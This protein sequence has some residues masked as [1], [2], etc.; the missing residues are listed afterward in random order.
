VDT[1]KNRSIE[2]TGLGLAIARNLCRLMGGDITVQSVYGEGSTF[3]AVIPQRVIDP[4][5]FG[6]GEIPAVSRVGKKLPDIK[7]IAPDAHILAVDDIDTNLTVLKGLLAPYQI[8]ITLCASGAEAIDLVKKQTFDFVLMDHMMPEMDGIET[9]AAI[10]EWQKSQR[11]ATT[12]FPQET[13]IIALTANAV[14]GMREMFFEKGFNDYLSKPIEIAKLDEL[15][16]KWVPKEK[17]IKTAAP[18]RDFFETGA[19]ISIPGIE[20][21]KGITMTG[22]T[23]EGYKKVLASFCKD[24]LNRLPQLEAFLDAPGEKRQYPEQDIAAFTTQIHALKSAAATIGAAELSREAAELET[25]G[26]A[27]DT[28]TITQNLPAFCAGLKVL[29]ENIQYAL[30]SPGES[31]PRSAASPATQAASPETQNKLAQLRTA[32]EEKN[33]EAIDRLIAEVE[34]LSLSPQYTELVNSISDSILMGKYPAAI[35]A[36]AALTVYFS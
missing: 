11:K 16:T 19:E 2:G 31:D 35:E 22:G 9:A 5:P 18:T 7:F 8:K 25:V 3:T 21:A 27:G 10:R 17:Q 13:P 23:L 36:L 12:E 33:M 6:S 14:S 26:K 28:R 34:K 1:H 29:T 30:Q 32:L 4:S 24:A 15:M 20:A